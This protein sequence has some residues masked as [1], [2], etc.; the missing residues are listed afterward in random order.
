MP[1]GG[2]CPGA[3]AAG[4][5]HRE[6]KRAGVMRSIGDS[7]MVDRR[8]A[9]QGSDAV[10]GTESSAAVFAGAYA[11]GHERAFRGQD[12][13]IMECAP[14][15]CL[16]SSAVDRKSA[17]LARGLGRQTSERSKRRLSRRHAYHRRASDP[18]SGADPLFPLGDGL[19]WWY[20][21]DAVCARRRRRELL[22][23]VGCQRPNDCCDCHEWIWRDATI[24]FARRSARAVALVRRSVR[25]WNQAG[26][27]SRGHRRTCGTITV[28]VALLCA[29]HATTDSTVDEHL[30]S[31]ATE[32]PQGGEGGERA[33]GARLE[34]G[35]A[36]HGVRR[37]R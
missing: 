29:G 23:G 8:S 21:R 22:I 10:R 27:F 16:T 18:E 12:R 34:G 5:T 2:Q 31:R 4:A 32:A 9:A 14:V 25:R 15:A 35:A 36:G 19:G 13:H 24:A 1:G 11:G 37:L 33:D 26:P 6:R 17:A 20:E 30:E 3:R 7:R 28:G